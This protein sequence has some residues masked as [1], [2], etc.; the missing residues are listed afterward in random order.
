MYL[1]GNLLSI[2]VSVYILLKTVKEQVL[3]QCNMLGFSSDP[4]FLMTGKKYLLQEHV[5]KLSMISGIPKNVILMDSSR[6]LLNRPV[7]KKILVKV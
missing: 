7:L 6:L 5:F 3:K 1:Y 4:K 2:P